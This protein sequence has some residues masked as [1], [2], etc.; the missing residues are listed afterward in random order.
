LAFLA[1]SIFCTLTVLL[2]LVFYFP[3]GFFRPVTLSR[4]A[5]FL[6]LSAYVSFFVCS[7]IA[8]FGPFFVIFVL[9]G[10]PLFPAWV[11]PPASYF[12]LPLFPWPRLR[13]LCLP[14]PRSPPDLLAFGSYLS[15]CCYS[16]FLLKDGRNAFVT[17][18]F[19]SPSP[20]PPRPRPLPF[21]LSS[22]HPEAPLPYICSS[23]YFPPRSAFCFLA[24]HRFS[25][26]PGHPL[27]FLLPFC[28]FS[29]LYFSL[30]FA[31]FTRVGVF[32]CRYASILIFLA[33]GASDTCSSP[34]RAVRFFLHVFPLPPL[35]FNLSVHSPRPAP[36]TR[37]TLSTSQP[38]LPLSAQLL[39]PLPPPLSSCVAPPG[40]VL[41]PR[42]FS[43]LIFVSSWTCLS[44]LSPLAAPRLCCIGE[45]TAFFSLLLWCGTVLVLLDAL[46][47]LWYF[48]LFFL[49]RGLLFCIVFLCVSAFYLIVLFST[50]L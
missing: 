48:L 40:F 27:S 12:P 21:P 15:G 50:L 28:L 29:S 3:A 13:P 36:L 38:P 6:R 5:V 9:R 39:F 37:D 45:S 11:P 46:L 49:C 34:V 43:P 41:V 31:V 30:V 16:L 14:R 44:F 4:Y 47:Y 10:P 1:V 33:Y 19:F 23:R 32:V 18:G 20:P 35:L 22:M 2:S 7:L 42:C 24:P 26:F 8:S 25:P 17:S